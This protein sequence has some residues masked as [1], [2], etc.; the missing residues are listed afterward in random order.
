MAIPF[1]Y[2]FREVYEGRDG[3]TDASQTNEYT[4]VFLAEFLFFDGPFGPDDAVLYSPC[5]RIL[6]VYVSA[7]GT[8]DL[9]SFC[10]KISA[11]NT[12]APWVWK[13]VCNYT[14]D[15]DLIN[16]S[17][18]PLLKP[19]EISWGN[20]TMQ[21][22]L[23]RAND[24]SPIQNTATEPFDPPPMWEEHWQTITMQKNWLT[25]DMVALNEYYNSVNDTPWFGFDAGEVK[26]AGIESKRE[27]WKNQGNSYYSVTYHFE[28]KRKGIDSW[29]YFILDAGYFQLVAGKLVAIRDNFGSPI[30]K[31]AL[32]DGVGAKLP[33]GGT[34][35][36]NR[37]YVYDNKEFN[38]L[39]VMTERLVFTEDAG[40]RI[41]S[42]VRYVEGGRGLFPRRDGVIDRGNDVARVR[43]T[44][45]TPDADGN[46]PAQVTAYD[47]NTPAWVDLGDPCKLMPVNSI[48]P[49]SGL[50]YPAQFGFLNASNEA[51][52]ILLDGPSG[53]GWT[54]GVGTAS[55]VTTT[56]PTYAGQ[57]VS[58]PTAGYYFFS[59][60]LVYL[61]DASNLATDFLYFQLVSSGGATITDIILANQPGATGIQ[62]TFTMNWS[63][64]ISFLTPLI[65]QLWAHHGGTPLSSQI[66]NGHFTGAAGSRTTMTALKLGSHL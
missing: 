51:A 5:P 3:K 53:L 19:T 32:L 8:V 34:P 12:G 26:C 31:P 30:S 20:K 13:I 14:S 46:Y 29:A 49:A 66:T 21:R 63:G 39:G 45:G 57:F 37:F 33:V 47:S 38:L 4:R 24:Q 48:I 65:V 15:I 64:A 54:D 55:L 43:V 17:G 59:V 52:F 9:N 60:N 18:N 28:A 25:I 41:A 62:Q 36:Y 16:P 11:T 23:E 40:N 6:D 10:S 42:A 44:S 58:I 35:V 7:A 27:F 56:T 22:V 61:F 2:S 50:Q 1:L